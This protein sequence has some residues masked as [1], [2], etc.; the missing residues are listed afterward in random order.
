ME[1]TASIPEI[2]IPA[3][4]AP[5]GAGPAPV[6]EAAVQA[7]GNPAAPAPS[8]ADGDSK[9]SNTFK[10]LQDDA[11]SAETAENGPPA[12]ARPADV[13][14]TKPA[15]TDV[16][17]RLSMAAAGIDPATL[18]AADEFGLPAS[19]GNELPADG[20][21]LPP[22]PKTLVDILPPADKATA[23]NAALTNQGTNAG[24]AQTV[25]T[26]A[27]ISAAVPPVSPDPATAAEA[28]TATAGSTANAA[29]STS[30]LPANLLLAKG[31]PGDAAA[32]T[33]RPLPEVVTESLQAPAD[34]AAQSLRNLLLQAA[35][36]DSP[37]ITLPQFA[38]SSIA[39]P[40]TQLPANAT[41]AF[42]DTLAELMPST[43]QQTLQP[44]GDR[45]MFAQGLG[46]RLVMMADNGLQS[47]RIKLYPERLGP[48]DIRVQVDDDGAKVWFHAQHGQTREALEQ[49]LPR[50]R[51]MFAEQGLEL[52]RS[53]VADGGERFQDGTRHAG[54]ADG[55]GNHV[56][57]GEQA[58]ELATPIRPPGLAVGG[59]RLLDVMA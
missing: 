59:A 16:D 20:E 37:R 21:A 31:R 43:G 18:D 47:A 49:A 54:D 3:T 51:E 36:G 58:G 46:E 30:G 6:R 48:L 44:T 52:V 19:G 40:M 11:P 5:P 12:A 13:A 53:E 1:T 39:P 55:S 9:F 15:A 34:N 22:L 57:G 29:A 35:P 2:L 8:D 23:G 14:T 38:D 32:D 41:A 25:T 56:D 33:P 17:A 4:P 26:L 27:A 45:G 42:T 7:P 10:S 50:L 24:A 28:L